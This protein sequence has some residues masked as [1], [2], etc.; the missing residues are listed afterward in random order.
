VAR[1]TTAPATK[2]KKESPVVTAQ[3]RLGGGCLETDLTTKALWVGPSDQ[4]LWGVD[5][6]CADQAS[7]LSARERT[8]GPSDPRRV[9]DS[10]SRDQ[11]NH[12]ELSLGAAILKIPQSLATTIISI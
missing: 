4:L 5:R 2:V 9:T 10:A 3:S 12:P 8:F 1:L 6:Q 11:E 7:R